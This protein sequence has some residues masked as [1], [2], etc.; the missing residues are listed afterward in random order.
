M[1]EAESAGVSR[2]ARHGGLFYG[3]WIVAATAS[4]QGLYSGLFWQAYGAYVVLLR[5]EFGWS[6]TMLS[7]AYSFAQAESGTIGPITGVL[8]DRFG[9]RAVMR[10]GVVI[11][12]LA[13]MGFS[14]VHTPFFFFVTFILIAIGAGMAGFLSATTAIVNWFE[15][16]R[17][18]AIG[19]VTAGFALG[20]MAVP[21]TVKL[22]ETFGWRA[23]AFGSGVAIL[24]LGLPLVQAVRHR[25]GPYGQ[26]PDGI[27]PD[28]PRHVAHAAARARGGP[29]FTLR[30]ALRTPSFWLIALGHGSALVIVSAVQVHTVAHVKE[31]LGYSLAGASGVITLMTMLQFTGTLTG[32]WLGDHINKRLLVVACMAMHAS[33]I[34]LLAHATGFA[35]VA[36][37]CVLHG[38]AWGIR[39]PQMTAIR[40]D[41][42]G[43]ASFGSIMGIS[44]IIV[45]VGSISGPIVAGVLYDATGSYIRGFD[46]LAA[47][48]LVGSLFFVAAAKP[49]APDARARGT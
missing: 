36:G 16:K 49:A 26:H 41:Y 10:A 18:T 7:T 9:P 4:L 21:G 2:P 20:G 23:T 29:D 5:D 12:G 15:R 30:Q 8:L 19:L 48:A 22:L 28:D 11:S 45:M 40:A 32:G 34:L 6:K 3:W 35:M 47:V 37:F 46:I 27:A 42:F 24:A 44:M 13:L 1:T 25:P 31:S 17:S 33:G 43:A 14:Q 38:L 39:G